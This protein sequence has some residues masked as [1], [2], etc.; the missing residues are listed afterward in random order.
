MYK[1]YT[2]RRL[3]APL[4]DRALRKVVMRKKDEILVGW[5]QK[6]TERAVLY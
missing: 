6:E 3:I 4:E 5:R 1:S 2:G